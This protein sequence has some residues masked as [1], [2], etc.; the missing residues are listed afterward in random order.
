MQNLELSYADSR[1]RSQ[2][3]EIRFTL[4]FHVC[5]KSPLALEGFSFNFGQMSI[6]VRRCAE[7]MTQFIDSRSRSQLNVMGFTLEFL[8]CSISPLPLEGVSLNFG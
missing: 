2:L 4:E 8:V 1:S 3:K 6:L 7:P 5:F